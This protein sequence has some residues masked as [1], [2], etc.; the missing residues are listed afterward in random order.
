VNHSDLVDVDLLTGEVTGE[1][2][3]TATVIVTILDD[4]NVSHKTINIDV[5]P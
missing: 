2:A 5:T 1:Q 4:S 3:G